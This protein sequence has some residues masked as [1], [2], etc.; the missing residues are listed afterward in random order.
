VQ[1]VLE[2]KPRFLSQNFT[3]LR[4]SLL[5]KRQLLAKRH[6]S[7]KSITAESG[8]SSQSLESI[9]HKPVSHQSAS[10]KIEISQQPTAL[11]FDRERGQW[12]AQAVEAEP[13]AQ[14]GLWSRL[15]LRI[16]NWLLTAVI[17]IALI[18]IGVIFVPRLYFAVFPPQA[19]QQEATSDGSPLGGLFKYKDW[20]NRTNTKIDSN[21][22]T[23]GAQI[24]DQG[25]QASAAANARDT[26]GQGNSPKKTLTPVPADQVEKRYV[27][28][29]QESLP[30]GDWLVISR[31][32]IRTQLQ[33]TS[34]P[35]EALDTGIWWVPDFGQPGDLVTPMIVAGHRY[36]WRW[37]W[38]SDYWR[39]HSFYN[40]PELEPGDIVEIISNQRKWTYEIYAGE[41]AT[42]ISDYQADLILYTCKFL[43]SPIRY[44]RYARLITPELRQK[45]KEAGSS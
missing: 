17:I 20:L 12:S 29:Q 3:Y 42:E 37:W 14:P 5:G 27:P 6:L 2:T 22:A 10:H 4:R 13:K 40:L 30:Q 44:F 26:D 34:D 19:V 38:K 33:A 41:E 23:A 18:V 28:P 36:G 7:Q 43:K 9:P 45:V 11:A 24:V 32:G 1:L 16:F 35:D 15:A 39:Y 25:Q 31:I 8:Q 21:Q